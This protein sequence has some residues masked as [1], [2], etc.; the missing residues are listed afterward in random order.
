MLREN[1]LIHTPVATQTDVW[2]AEVTPES[3][4][5][6]LHTFLR[7]AGSPDEELEQLLRYSPPVEFL[8]APETP[9]EY[10]HTSDRPR[11]LTSSV[12][13][14]QSADPLLPEFQCPSPVTS[15]REVVNRSLSLD[16]TSP[17]QLEVSSISTVLCCAVLCCT[18]LCWYYT[19]LYCAGTILY[20]TVLV[21]Y[22]TVLCWYY[23]MLQCI[24]LYC[25]VLY[26]TVLYC[27]VLVLY[28]TVLYFA[29]LCC[30]V[31]YCAGTILYCAVLYCTVLYCAV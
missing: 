26:C 22:C 11:S 6:T 21:L 31:L 10:I 14:L 29:V 13:S 19:V 9:H 17:P 24:V 1:E 2:N 23:T 25:T 12:A 18:V 20:C 7:S 27:T 8:H 28:C 5:E 15:E 3:S 30:T 16:L 4:V